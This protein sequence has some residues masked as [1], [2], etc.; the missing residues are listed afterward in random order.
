MEDRSSW[1]FTGKTESDPDP[2]SRPP[3]DALQE[4]TSNVMSAARR[5]SPRCTCIWVTESSD[6]TRRARSAKAGVP[7]CLAMPEATTAPPLRSV[8]N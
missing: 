6:Q 5:A 8:M 1:T 7:P 3:I 4:V 2:D